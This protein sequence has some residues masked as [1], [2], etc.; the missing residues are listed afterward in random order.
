MLQSYSP[1]HTRPL[2]IL[3]TPRG[4]PRLT[5]VQEAL[6]REAQVQAHMQA[7]APLRRCTCVCAGS[8]PLVAGLQGGQLV[9]WHWR[10]RGGAWA[11]AAAAEDLE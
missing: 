2:I 11:A 8:M 3:R 7:Q 6:M 10:R 1:P 4:A 5:P 9:F